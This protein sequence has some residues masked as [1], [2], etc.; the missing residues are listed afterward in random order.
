MP[1]INL[2]DNHQLYYALHRSP[3]PGP[4][5]L[6]LLHGA[7]GTH[8]DWPAAIRRLPGVT[9]YAL[10]LPGHGRSQPPGC[11]TVA[12]YAGI[13]ARFIARLQLAHVVLVGHSMGG[14]IAMTLALNASPGIV[15][16]VLAGTGARLRVAPAILEGLMTDP[17]AV[18]DLLVNAYWQPDTPSAVKQRSKQNLLAVD[19]TVALGDFE[20]CNT[21][22]VRGQL[23]QI[24]LPTLV[25][26][27]DTDPL[28][29]LKYSQYLAAEIPHARLVTLPAAGHMLLL[30]HPT[31]A[32]AAITAFLQE[33]I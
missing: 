31:L 1:T 5:N 13:V 15:G 27:S 8:L 9:V 21:F 22:D 4:L 7:A 17:A 2:D 12:D 19:P 26:G 23:G 18:A 16:L 20:A 10:D 33:T 6:L 3:T 30:A 24:Q 29:P 14:A 28:T 32:A 11:R 25:I